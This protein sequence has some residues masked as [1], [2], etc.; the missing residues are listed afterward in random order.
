MN[1]GPQIGRS[2]GDHLT[3]ASIAWGN[4]PE[5]IVALAEAC[6]RSS[7]SAVAK[8]LDYSP[9]TISQVLSNN[10]RGDLGRIEEMV[11]GALL[12]ET[13]ICPAL[14]ELARNSCL[15]WQGKPYAATSSHRVQMYRAC[16]SNCPH[17]RISG[18]QTQ[19]E[20]A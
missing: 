2:A 19:G 3:K 18:T 5:W 15:D 12:A 1:R 16:R 11:R 13:I 10:Y 7:Q 17:S 6:G 8:Q 4:P 9:A 20:D 14:G